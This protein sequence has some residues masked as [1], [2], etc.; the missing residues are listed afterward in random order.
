M[1]EIATEKR[2]PPPW[3][4]KG[5]PEYE[6]RL[7][8][9]S[10][11]RKAAVAKKAAE[12]KAAPRVRQPEP[13]DLIDPGT[14]NN[15]RMAPPTPP[16]AKK[17]AA[18]GKGEFDQSDVHK[19]IRLACDCLA[20]MPGHEH[21]R[22][23]DDEIECVAEPATR[24]LNRLDR[25]LI[26]KM[27]SVSDPAALIFAVVMVFGPSIAEEVRNV[28]GPALRVSGRKKRSQH[29]AEPRQQQPEY[30]SEEEAVG[31]PGGSFVPSSP[32]VSS[33]GADPLPT[34]PKI[35]PTGI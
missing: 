32:A 10:E 13:E 11:G 18:R 30:Q 7:K 24:I 34:V 27:R 33:N 25:K 15:A 3:P 9:M 20:T 8:R 14:P 23:D 31:W 4:E 1:V 21:W 2:I 5:T 29:P 12:K 6:A 16:A 35:H 22:R 17:P 26:E 19:N 28:K